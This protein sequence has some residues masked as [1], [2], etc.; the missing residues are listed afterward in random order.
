MFVGQVLPESVRQLQ[1]YMGDGV[2]LAI[3][4]LLKSPHESLRWIGLQYDPISAFFN[5]VPY[6]IN[7]LDCSKF[8]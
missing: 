6:R 2:M 4:Q 3:L 7:P 5:R 1:D 8:E